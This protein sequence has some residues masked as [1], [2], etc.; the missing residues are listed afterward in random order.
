MAGITLAQAEATLAEYQAAETKALAGQSYSINTGSG[1]RTL[2]R[3]NLK[4]IREGITYWHGM[5]QKLSPVSA[6]RRVRYVVPE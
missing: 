3:A 6:R 5:V 2:T 4:D 1:S